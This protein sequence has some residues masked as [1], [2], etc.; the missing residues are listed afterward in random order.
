MIDERIRQLC[1]APPRACGPP[2][3]SGRLRTAPEDF[4]VDEL[5]GF[6]PAGAGHHTLLRVRKRQANTEWVARQLAREARVKPFDV[7]YAGLKDRHA[8]ATQWFSVPAGRR[9]PQSWLQFA[10]EGFAVLEAHAHARKLPRGALAGNRFEIRV[11]GC[12]VSAEALQQR[13]QLIV[14]GGVPNYFG[15]QRFGRDL[16][17][18]QL[19]AGARAGGFQISAA[20]SLIFNAVLAARVTDGSWNRLLPGELANLDGSGSHFAVA[21]VD[22]DLQ[23]RLEAL[24]IHPSGPLWGEGPPQPGA[25]LARYEAAI[26]QEFPAA[27]ATLAGAGAEAARRSLR[28]AAHDLRI[29]CEQHDVLLRFE[30][31]SGG[32]A[33]TV[34]REF[35]D[36]AEQGDADAGS[37]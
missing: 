21:S 12:S 36:V 25:E 22:A 3:G 34:L 9:E 11:R 35:F 23:A 17:N 6:E 24:D 1:L 37:S 26:A 18:L 29:E 19:A 14:R 8:V 30:L 10:G 15:P 7:G 20:R 5:L 4:V 28:L 33:T 16:G 31:R 13:A 2:L 27:L 32:F